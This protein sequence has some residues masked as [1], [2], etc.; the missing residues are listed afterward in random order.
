[1]HVKIKE[2]VQSHL[3][4]PD[5]ANPESWISVHRS[6]ETDFLQC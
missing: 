4:N 1:M 5:R 2:Y 3:V 6:Q